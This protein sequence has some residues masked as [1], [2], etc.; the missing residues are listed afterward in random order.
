MYISLALA[1]DSVPLA[2]TLAAF[3]STQAPALFLTLES[4]D[5]VAGAET[6]LFNH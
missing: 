4:L 6:S 5:E 1:E 2:S 3:F